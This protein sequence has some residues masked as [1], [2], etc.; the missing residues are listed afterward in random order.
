VVTVVGSGGIG[1]TALSAAFAE[2]FGWHFPGGVIGLTLANRPGLAPETL[3][4]ELLERLSGG[5]LPPHLADAPA[6]WL[7]E[8]FLQLAR[9]QPPLTILDNYESVLQVTHPTADP[10]AAD[11][12][13][14]ALDADAARFHQLVYGLANGGLPLLLTSRQQPAELP[15]EQIFPPRQKALPGLAELAGAQLFIYHSSRAKQAATPAFA[16]AGVG[17]GPGPGCYV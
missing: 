13:Q 8:I 12:G 16:P 10:E 6:E 7:A 9:A 5:Q 4:R 15:G 2:R 3:F 11:Q 17:G 1:K 14:R